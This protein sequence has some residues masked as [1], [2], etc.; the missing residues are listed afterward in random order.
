[1][2]SEYD[3][4]PECWREEV[5]EEWMHS[6]W[7]IQLYCTK[8]AS[9]WIRVH[10]HITCS[11]CNMLSIC[12]SELDFPGGPSN[13]LLS[14]L[15]MLITQESIVYYRGNEAEC[16]RISLSCQCSYSLYALVKSHCISAE[17]CKT[18]I[19]ACRHNIKYTFF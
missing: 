18:K 16:I 3:C 17:S 5:W 13:S 2:T 1:M 7:G 11:H 12:K 9:C 6:K 14:E 15:V 19:V 8:C 4:H 10:V